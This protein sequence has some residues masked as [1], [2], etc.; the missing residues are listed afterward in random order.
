VIDVFF[1]VFGNEAES[2]ILKDERQVCLFLNNFERGRGSSF[3]LG[4]KLCFLCQ[5]LKVT[6]DLVFPWSQACPRWWSAA[7]VAR[8]LVARKT[9]K[10]RLWNFSVNSRPIFDIAS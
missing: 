2:F 6:G 7:P 1:L 10:Q 9:R 5:V 8:K 4:F 3:M